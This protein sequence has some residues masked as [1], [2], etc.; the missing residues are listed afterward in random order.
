[1]RK[2]ARGS[3]LP[4]WWEHALKASFPALLSPDYKRFDGLAATNALELAMEMLHRCFG[5]AFI[6]ILYF[7]TLSRFDGELEAWPVKHGHQ[8]K[9]CSQREGRGTKPK[10]WDA[11]PSLAPDDGALQEVVRENGNNCQ[12]RSHEG[13]CPNDVEN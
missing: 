5:I 6:V 2:P 7:F 4:S 13:H 12:A 1:M 10:E 8:L 3:L 11:S 9:R